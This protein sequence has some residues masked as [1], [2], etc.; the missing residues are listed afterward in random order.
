MRPVG[1]ADG[2]RERLRDER[3][4][5]AALVDY[6]ATI[7]DCFSLSSR[8]PATSSLS[9]AASMVAGSSSTLPSSSD[10]FEDMA[11]CSLSS[12][13]F[14]ACIPTTSS[15]VTMSPASATRGNTQTERFCVLVARPLALI[16]VACRRAAGDA[17]RRRVPGPGRGLF[18]EHRRHRPGRRHSLSLGSLKRRTGLRSL[19]YRSSGPYVDREATIRR[20]YAVVVEKWISQRIRGRL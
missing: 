2:C 8:R 1:G 18:L 5:Q 11:W 20:D 17:D 12:R 3:T 9:R 4:V 10:T 6:P 15:N 13:S 14:W 16:L 19:I 7:L